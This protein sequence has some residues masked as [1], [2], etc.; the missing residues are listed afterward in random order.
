MNNQN[1]VEQIT[2]EL[3]K[4]FPDLVIE[5]FITKSDD[6]GLQRIKELSCL[7]ERKPM[8]MLG[9]NDDRVLFNDELGIKFSTKDKN[10][11]VVIKY[12][13]AWGIPTA[14][15]FIDEF[16]KCANNFERDS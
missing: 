12:T 15:Y 6:P 8:N 11:W 14:D 5:S 4:D 13:Y 10:E 7:L 1:N 16:E 2:D 3:K 9:G